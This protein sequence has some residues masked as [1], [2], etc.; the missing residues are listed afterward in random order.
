[1]TVNL[2]LARDMVLLERRLPRTLSHTEWFKLEHPDQL[3][4]LDRAHSLCDQMRGRLT[5][6]VIVRA[7]S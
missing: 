1:M 5:N 7:I 3:E 2:L 4:V 6:F